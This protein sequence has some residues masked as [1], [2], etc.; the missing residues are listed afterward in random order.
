MGSCIS[1]ERCPK[2]GYY[3]EEKDLGFIVETYYRSGEVYAGCPRCHYGY[4]EVH[5]PTC[6]RCGAQFV[7]PTLNDLW[8]YDGLRACPVCGSPFIRWE[9]EF[10]D[11]IRTDFVS[12][13]ISK[14]HPVE[15][16]IELL[17]EG[18][19]DG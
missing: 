3:D 9:L 6:I 12:I 16:L 11:N 7:P 10:F 2:C 15:E 8:M 14:L 1:I 19:S 13:P 17:K 4:R 18:E 5:I